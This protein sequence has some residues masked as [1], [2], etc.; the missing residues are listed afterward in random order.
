[1]TECSGSRKAPL[2]TIKPQLER[3]AIARATVAFDNHKPLKGNYTRLCIDSTSSGTRLVSS[4]NF[5][6]RPNIVERKTVVNAWCKVKFS[7]DFNFQ[8]I[9]DH[10]IPAQS[11]DLHQ[12]LLKDAPLAESPRFTC[13]EIK[14]I[15][16]LC[17]SRDPGS[18][19]EM[20]TNQL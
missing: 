14:P 15:S 20:R 12:Q 3:T 7:R 8:A 9:Q 11:T 5:G 6:G 2:N 13:V 10:C 18:P 19:E 4:H 16:H 17:A 1:M